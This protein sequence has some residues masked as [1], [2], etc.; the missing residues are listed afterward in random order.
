[1]GAS[2]ATSLHHHAPR[3]C[4][5][6][7]A[8]PLFGGVSGGFIS[9][10]EITSLRHIVASSCATS[11]VTSFAT[12]LRHVMHAT[13]CCGV[14]GDGLH[15]SVDR[16]VTSCATSLRHVMRHIVATLP[17]RHRSRHAAVWRFRI[18]LSD[19]VRCVTSVH[20][21]LHHIVRHIVASH[22]A[23]HRYASCAAPLLWRQ[24][25]A[26]IGRSLASRR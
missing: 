6:S 22:R 18:G 21:S 12:S 3:R 17:L 4:V 25:H 5:A 11:C 7:C 26:I 15:H 9:V 13:R 16:C 23:P 10:M 1:M 8:A 2:C 20:T 24:D 14:S 19:V